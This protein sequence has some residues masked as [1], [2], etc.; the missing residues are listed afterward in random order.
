MQAENFIE[1]DNMNNDHVAIL[2]YIHDIK[3]NITSYN[4]AISL[5]DMKTNLDNNSFRIIKGKYNV[6]TN[7]VMEY[8]N[9]DHNEDFT[10]ILA[11]CNKISSFM[12][13]IDNII[14][15]RTI[16]FKYRTAQLVKELRHNRHSN[17][18]E[19]M[20]NTLELYNEFTF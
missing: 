10:Q 12:N 5:T 4:E 6:L 13:S 7:M 3:D 18:A 15:S 8:L 2:A 1:I 14:L 16:E 20:L 9:H 17:R 11:D 19:E